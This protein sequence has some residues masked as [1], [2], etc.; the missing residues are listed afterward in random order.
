MGSSSC[1]FCSLVVVEWLKSPNPLNCQKKL[2]LLPKPNVN[3][4]PDFEGPRSRLALGFRTRLAGLVRLGFFFLC[5]GA[6]SIRFE[7]GSDVTPIL[8]AKGANLPFAWEKGFSG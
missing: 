4:V 7:C 6:R 3:Q 2:F 5:E 1:T 8:G